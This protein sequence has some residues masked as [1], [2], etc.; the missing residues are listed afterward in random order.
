MRL[1]EE[2]ETKDLIIKNKFLRQQLQEVSEDIDDAQVSIMQRRGFR[3]RDF[4]DDRSFRVTDHTMELT[5]KAKERFVDMRTRETDNGSRK[6]ISHPIHNKPIFGYANSLIKRL[7][8]GF[9]NAV[10]EELARDI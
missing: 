4:Y 9:T 5:H 1:L 7:H 3:S 8:F 10:K 2:R 6:K